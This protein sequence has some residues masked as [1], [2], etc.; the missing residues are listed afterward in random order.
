MLRVDLS[1]TFLPHYTRPSEA[2]IYEEPR[3]SSISFSWAGRV[4]A[5]PAIEV[6]RSPS[7]V[8]RRGSKRRNMRRFTKAGGILLGV[9]L[10]FAP[11][12]AAAQPAAPAPTNTIRGRI[13]DSESQL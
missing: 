2:P 1:C 4:R 5:R 12:G 11:L 3:P 7:G 8:S 10:G 13:V 6:S 9:L